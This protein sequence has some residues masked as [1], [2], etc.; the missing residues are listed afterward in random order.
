MTFYNVIS[1]VVFFGAFRE[2]LVALQ[3]PHL[4]VPALW[5]AALVALLVFNDAIFTSWTTETRKVD[6]GPGLMSIDLVNFFLLSACLLFLNPGV[7]NVFEL[8]L[9]AFVQK[10]LPE[11][12]FWILLAIYW[13]LVMAWTKQAGVY[14][15][16]KYPKWLIPLAAGIVVVFLVESAVVQIFGSAK[17]NSVSHFFSAIAFLYP[18]VY[19]LGIRSYA[20]R[21]GIDGP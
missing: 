18:A 14:S 19:I 9:T 13:A 17:T 12:G 6:Y 11:S 7:T 4:P 3:G 20:L 16:P 8:D 2:L 1:A 10:W 21:N 15:K 5:Q